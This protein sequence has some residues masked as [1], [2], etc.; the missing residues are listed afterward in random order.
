MRVTNGMIAG[1]VTFNMQRSLSRFMDL[2]AQMSSG[3]RLNKPS[4]DP[5]GVMRDLDYRG[6]LALNEQLR[7]N[8]SQAQNWMQNY[9]SILSSLTGAM[10]D[11]KEITISMAN[12][13][14]DDVA[15]Q[16]TADEVKSIF[17]QILSL[18]GTELEGKRMFSGF[19][20]DTEPLRF[21]G[22]GVVYH[23]DMGRI[24]FQVDQSTKMDINLIGSDI[25][26]KQLEKLG[27]FSDLNTGIIGSTLLADLNNGNG[28]DLSVGTFTIDDKNLGISV[29][30]DISA[31]IDIDD[32]LTTINTALASNVP[33]ITNLTAVISPGNN[34]IQFKP[35]PSD[36]ISLTTPLAN[37]NAGNGINLD[38]GQI[39]L[40]D[41]AGLNIIVDLSGS[42]TLDDIITKFNAAIAAA[43][44]VSNVTMQLNAAGTGLEIN[45]TNGVPLGLVVSEIDSASTTASD[46]GLTGAIDPTLTGTDLMP[47][48][49]FKISEDGGTIAADFGILGRFSRDFSGIDLDPAFSATTNISQLNNGYGYPL[50]TIDLR[51]GESIRTIDLGDP[52]IVTVQDL[53]DAINNSGLDVTASINPDGRGIQVVSN[54]PTRSFIISETGEGL[55]AK[56][57]GLFGSSDMMGSLILLEEALRAD[58][59]RGVGDLLDNVDKALQNV[60]NSRASVGAKGLRLETTNARLIDQELS[61]IRLL[62][63]VEDADLTKLITELATSENNF[64]A[65][66]LASAKIIQPSLLDFLR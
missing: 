27:E 65:S 7:G 9:D 10:T 5:L 36:Q 51:L 43:P 14:Y 2:Q 6:E 56:E 49:D 12:S 17:E 41:G 59:Q 30:V 20:T 16:A 25:F 54:D 29:N 31:A 45:D 13:T 15:R 48:N 64:R 62:S 32:V 34:S 4:D 1:L 3:R 57:L 66:L 11:I 55:T 42:V 40:S 26:L 18:S 58:D 50:G 60:L 19:R 28:I 35:T 33:P 37:L 46:L 21:A 8:I 47:Q 44:G 63:E 24:R 38:N 39:S 52:A 23:G 53:M 61:F 22:N